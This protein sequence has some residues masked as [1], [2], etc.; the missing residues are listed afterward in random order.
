MEGWRV[1]F[2]SEEEL[3]GSS[4]QEERTLLVTNDS[5]YRYYIRELLQHQ[6]TMY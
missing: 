5:L 4:L 2:V 3:S 6:S 1:V